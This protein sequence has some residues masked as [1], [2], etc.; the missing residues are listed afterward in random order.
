MLQ[1]QVLQQNALARLDIR[2]PFLQLK[3]TDP[4]VE[5]SSQPMTMKFHTP[6]AEVFIDNYPSD[7][8]RG[9]RNNVDFDRENAQKGMQ[10][11]ISYIGKAAREGARMAKLEHKGI[12]KQLAKEAMQSRPLEISI[13]SVKE[14]SIK[15]VTHDATIEVNPGRV[16]IEGINGTVSGSLQKGTVDLTMLRYPEVKFR[17]VDSKVDITV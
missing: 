17:A 13:G 7:Y 14:P 12:L 6:A 3:I 5:I 11:L 2:D 8:S 4:H 15:V 1:V 10:A 9:Y 16:N